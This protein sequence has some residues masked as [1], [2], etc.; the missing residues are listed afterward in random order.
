MDGGKPDHVPALQLSTNVASISTPGKHEVVFEFAGS[1]TT[2][3][4]SLGAAVFGA[5]L[6]CLLAATKE[7]DQTEPANP[8]QLR[9]RPSVKTKNDHKEAIPEKS[10]KK[11]D[12]IDVEVVPGQESPKK[13][14]KED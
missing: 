11:L 8:A 14:Q 12:V 6:C 5:V 3:L 13:K 1:Y 10:K 2:F 4:V 9:D 7:P